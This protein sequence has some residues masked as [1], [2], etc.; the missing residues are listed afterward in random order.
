VSDNPYR[1]PRNVL[2]VHYELRLEPDLEAFTF[3]GHVVVDLD[4]R[5]QVSEIVL[6]TSEIDFVSVSDDCV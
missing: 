6:N 5:E 2:P 1:L 4:V 3:D